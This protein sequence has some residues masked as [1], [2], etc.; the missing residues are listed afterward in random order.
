M[1]VPEA[2]DEVGVVERRVACK[3]MEPG[4]AGFL[5]QRR[6]ERV[7]LAESR[8]QVLSRN[9]TLVL[10][11]KQG[12]GS[13][14]EFI[15]GC[16]DITKRQIVQ[17]CYVQFVA[18]TLARNKV[19]R[20]AKIEEEFNRIKEV[21][22]GDEALERRSAGIDPAVQHLLAAGVRDAQEGQPELQ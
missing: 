16:E 10:T 19:C 5:G 13:R 18:R 14:M 21:E 8:L 1:F 12:N 22:L 2:R 6:V 15:T 3:M 4:L 20:D 9:K 17:I 11:E 7:K